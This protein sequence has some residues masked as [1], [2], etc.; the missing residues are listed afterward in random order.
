M[1][2]REEVFDDP[3]STN[4]GVYN[5]KNLA[6]YAFAYNNPVKYVDPDGE[7]PSCVW[8][9]IIGAGVDYGLQVAVN[10]AE[11]KRGSEAFTNVNLTSIFVSAGAGALSGG[12]S[13]LKQVKNAG[14][15]AK[16]GIG[17]ATDTGISVTSQGIKAG[18]VT[19]KDTA[20]D[21]LA[22]GIATGVGGMIEKKLV[23]S[24][25]GKKLTAALNTEK[26][27]ARGKSNL[28]PKG[29]ANIK[30]AANKL[31]KYVGTR[32]TAAGAVSSGAAST[33]YNK[34]EQKNAQK[35]DK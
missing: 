4:G 22:G 12:I 18:K 30:A 11:G 7:C 17:M 26:N 9:A 24:S 2:L 19:L 20:I 21:V 1:M 16:I 34:I 32:A 5:G 23:N 25:T 15:F 10:F 8:G 29:K 27:I 14:T 13:S 6:S 3:E 28:V 35:K 33:T 31:E